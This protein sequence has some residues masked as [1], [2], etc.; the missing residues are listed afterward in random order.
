ML[1]LVSFNNGLIE[2]IQMTAP[3]RKLMELISYKK[4]TTDKTLTQSKVCIQKN[5]LFLADSKETT[6][7]LCLVFIIWTALI[8]Q[9]CMFSA[10]GSM[11]TAH[12]PS[13]YRNCSVCALSIQKHCKQAHMSGIYPYNSHFLR[14]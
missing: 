5:T 4:E 7:S 10:D 14:F 11:R 3:N 9:L 12:T 8:G 2:K 13:L 6:H 1:T